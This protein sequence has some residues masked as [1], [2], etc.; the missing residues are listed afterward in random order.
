M[1][2]ASILLAAAGLLGAACATGTGHL[3]GGNSTGTT[4]AGSVTILRL[5]PGV[6]AQAEPQAQPSLAPTSR[7][8][9]TRPALQSRPAQPSASAAPG[10]SPTNS[11][12]PSPALPHS[13]RCL[14]SPTANSHQPQPM[15]ALP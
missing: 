8:P 13:D 4:S 11:S 6:A 2:K 14:G 15:C 1:R 12:S 3:T 9:L 10:A 7:V 5:Q